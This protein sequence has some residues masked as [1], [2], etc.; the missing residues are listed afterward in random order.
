MD[1]VNEANLAALAA[2]ED[3]NL[4]VAFH[5]VDE[6]TDLRDLPLPASLVA[7]WTD[8]DRLLL[9]FDRRR[10]AWE[11]PGGQIDLGE[12]PRQAA[13][14][15]LCEESGYEVDPLLFAGFA[16]FMLGAERR[17]EY[18]AVFTGRAAPAGSFIPNDEIAAITWWDGSATL[19]GRVQ[20]L[21]VC[22]GRLAKAALLR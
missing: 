18:A 4:L 22:L 16:R 17:A 7:L 6:N 21:D 15:E 3:G 11:L 8:D 1:R 9:V 14:R 13:V 10:Q 19:A 20:P 12:T 2:D 5:E